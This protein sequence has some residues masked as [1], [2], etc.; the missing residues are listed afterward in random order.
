MLNGRTFEYHFC[1]DMFH[2]LPQYYKFSHGL[3]LNNFLQVWLIGNQRYQVIPFRYINWADE[4]SHLVIGRKVL[5]DKKYLMRPV[6]QREETVEIWTEDNWD[7]RRV[8]SLYTILFGRFNF[9][10]NERLDSLIWSSVVWY[11]YRIRCFINGELNEEQEQAWK[12]QK[13]KM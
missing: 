3:C 12:A 13:K 2:M 10:R 11:F 4:V 7:V 8:N 9:K 5:E 1:G 6:K